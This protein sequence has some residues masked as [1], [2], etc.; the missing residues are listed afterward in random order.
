MGQA[1]QLGLQVSDGNRFRA[2]LE[3]SPFLRDVISFLPSYQ[4]GEEWRGCL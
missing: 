4:E 3:M 2:D 1:K